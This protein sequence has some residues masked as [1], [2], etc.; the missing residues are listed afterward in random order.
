MNSILNKVVM[1][2]FTLSCSMFAMEEELDIHLTEGKIEVRKDN[3]YDIISYPE[4]INAIGKEGNPSLPVMFF[5]VVAPYN[6]SE[7]GVR[8]EKIEW[9]E[10]PGKFY[11]YPIQPPVP[12]S[13]THN[14]TFVQPNPEVYEHDILYPA[15][16]I[17]F[18]GIGNC[19]GF[20]LTNIAFCPFRYFP[21]SRTLYFSSQVKIKITYTINNKS[22]R[23]TKW[24]N[25]TF[26]PLIMSMVINPEEVAMFSPPIR[27][28][29]KGS[30]YLPPGDYHEVY[31]TSDELVPHFQE[32]VY[33][34]TKQGIPCT[35]L[36]VADIITTYPG[37]DEPEKIRNFIKDADTTWGSIYFTLAGDTAHMPTRILYNELGAN[38]STD[39]YFSDLDSTWDADGDH[40]YGEQEDST[41][42]DWY[43]DVFVGRLSTTTEDHVNTFLWKIFTYEKNPPPGYLKKCLLPAA[44][45]WYPY[46]AD[47]VND[48]IANCTPLDWQDSKL[49]EMLGNVNHQI[50][51]DSLNAGFGFVH[52]GG[53]GNWNGIYWDASIDTFVHNLDIPTLTNG[54]KLGIHNSIACFPGFFDIIT[55]SCLLNGDCLAENLMNCSTGGAVAVIMNSRVGLGTPPTMGPSEKLDLEFY[56]KVFREDIHIVGK[57]HALS[58]DVYVPACDTAVHYLFCILELNLFGDPAMPMWLDEPIALIVDHPNS[59][60]TGISQVTITVTDSRAP[61]ENALVCL[62]SKMGEIYEYGYTDV[63]GQVTFTINPTQ[64]DTLW[65]TTTA[66]NHLP[67]E[68]FAGIHAVGI[69]EIP[70]N[71]AAFTFSLSNPRPNVFTKKTIIEYCIDEESEVYLSVYNA[72]GQNVGYLVDGTM[73]QK[74][75]YLINWGGSFKERNL[76]SGVYFLKLTSGKNTAVR[77]ILILE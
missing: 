16:P 35:T 22:F 55:D 41:A 1:I 46:G 44:Y 67:D 59:I 26:T 38:L 5:T 57:A 15:H 17:A 8:I 23:R 33:W 29:I 62:M 50:T 2:L 3:R 4:A 39:L 71:D 32:I 65:I 34:R 76:T 14:R 9:Q 20:K 36:T 70:E 74:G 66:K 43:S 18:N 77:K 54:N 27:T 60:P 6:V 49:Y 56:R 30:P 45:L 48:S 7:A 61:V 73:H 24:Q 51:L 40:I 53:H 72:L 28:G 11:I 47:I 75:R 42:C 31:I 58:K 69:E 21:R 63:G 37:W 12:L 68:S 64:P 19:G 25:R 10:L 13:Y 52:Y